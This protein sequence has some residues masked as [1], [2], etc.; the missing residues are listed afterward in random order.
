[1]VLLLLRGNGLCRYVSKQIPL[2]GFIFLLLGCGNRRN[3]IRYSPGMYYFLCRLPVGGKL[4]VPRWTFVGRIEYRMLKKG[5][6]G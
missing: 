3:E 5:V 4:P 6:H 1:M 2:F